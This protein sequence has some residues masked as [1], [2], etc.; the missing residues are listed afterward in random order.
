MTYL[1]Y[2][3]Y[4]RP[5][6]PSQKQVAFWTEDVIH[7]TYAR[8]NGISPQCFLSGGYM[9]PHRGKWIPYE[10]Y[11]L[12]NGKEKADKTLVRKAFLGHTEFQTPELVRKV[13]QTYLME[14]RVWKLLFQRKFKDVLRLLTR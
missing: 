4:I 1:R 7:A 14:H 10:H 2:L 11:Q 8:E 3:V 12:D 6:N 9:R 13:H 5:E